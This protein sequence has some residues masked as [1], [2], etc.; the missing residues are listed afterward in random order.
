MRSS[1]QRSSTSEMP[2][3]SVPEV[4]ASQSSEEQRGRQVEQRHPQLGTEPA[5]RLRESQAEVQKNGRR[6]Q[7]GRH[8]AEVDDLIEAVQL[9]G[10]M[11]ART[12]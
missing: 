5:A 6:E 10:V 9:A 1:I 11:E 7:T 2:I 3:R 4:T 12:R 8:I